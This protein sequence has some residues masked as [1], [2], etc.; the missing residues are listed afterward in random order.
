MSLEANPLEWY[1]SAHKKHCKQ[2]L[3]MILTYEL[4]AGTSVTR[5]V[6]IPFIICFSKGIPY[7]RKKPPAPMW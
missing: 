7:H 4:T 6:S 5:E 2:E 3:M 1:I